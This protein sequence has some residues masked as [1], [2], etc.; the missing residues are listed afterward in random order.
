MTD[1]LF[2]PDYDAYRLLVQEVKEYAIYMIDTNGVILTWNEGGQRLKGYTPEEAIGQHFSIFYTPEDITAGKPAN[3]LKIAAAEGRF[4]DEGWRLRKD[5]TRFWASVALTALHDRNGRV[6]AFGKVTRDMSE[7]KETEEALRKQAEQ[8][9]AEIVERRIAEQQL[10]DARQQLETRV[11]ERTA[12]LSE[13]N[14]QLAQANRLKDEFLATLSHELRTPLTAIVGWVQMLRA[15]GLTEAQAER[16]MEVIDRNLGVQTQLIDDLL[17]ISRIITGKLRVDPQLIYPAVTVREVFESVRPTLSAKS[18]KLTSEVDAG[19]GPIWIDPARFHQIVW[20]LLSNAVKFTPKGGE[21]QVI[22]ARHGSQAML[23][24]RDTGEGIA[25]EFLPYVFDRFRQADASHSRRH[26]GLGLGL[27]IVRHLVE[28]HGGTV[29]A[30][31]AGTGRGSTFTVKFPI[32][33]F[34]HTL[35]HISESQTLSTTLRGMHI[36]IVEDEEDTRDM[37]ARALERFGAKVF[38]AASAE[39]AFQLLRKDHV[40][41]IVSDIGMPNMDGYTFIRTIRSLNTPIRSL[42]AV[43]LTAY[44]GEDNRNSS[45][46]AGFDIHLSKPVSLAELVRAVAG[47]RNRIN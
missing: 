34:P 38:A 35:K 4:A 5:G 8:L 19:L 18:L 7:R 11:Q 6:W 9:R 25:P 27:A 14:E 36:L 26:G 40:D 31:S 1:S 42:P 12:E 41:I 32:A 43:A 44:A 30:E 15:G 2:E 46:Q 45:L 17:N 23:T 37:I 20:N 3:A 29:T 13:V 39:D 10:L 22:L 33:V 28:L 47:L 21:I 16:A 24:V